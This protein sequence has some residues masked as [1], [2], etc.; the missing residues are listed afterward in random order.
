MEDL[1]VLR[2]RIDDID[3]QIVALYEER[4]KVSEMVGRF[5]IE[6][7]RKVFDKKRE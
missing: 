7:G 3:R 2:D 5:K 4:M 1:S 6:N